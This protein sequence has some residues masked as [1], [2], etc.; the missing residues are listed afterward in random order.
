MQNL[1]GRV[2]SPYP[3]KRISG[4]GYT[5][6]RRDQYQAAIDNYDTAI[7]LKPD[8]AFAYLRRGVANYLLDRNWAAK[9]DWETALELAKQT[10][11][12]RLKAQT[13]KFLKRVD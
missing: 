6:Y 8:Y 5:K 3:L 12:K 10:G 11:N 2:H 7:S 1:C 4:G 13:E 9:K